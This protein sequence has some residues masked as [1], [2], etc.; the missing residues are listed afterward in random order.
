MERDKELTPCAQ[1]KNPCGELPKSTA[2]VK[3]PVEA[4]DKQ[5]AVRRLAQFK[6]MLPKATTLVDMKTNNVFAEPGT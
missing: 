4:I 2:S 6:N 1:R 5:E 3:S